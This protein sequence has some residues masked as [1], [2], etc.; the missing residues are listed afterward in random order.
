MSDDRQVCPCDSERR[1]AG[2]E[3]AASGVTPSTLSEGLS[4][5]GA[6]QGRSEGLL[7]QRRNPVCKGD[8]IMLDAVLVLFVTFAKWHMDRNDQKSK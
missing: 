7:L 1:R 8:A 4:Q 6:G 2:P 3:P 5:E